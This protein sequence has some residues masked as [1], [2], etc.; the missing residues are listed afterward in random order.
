MDSVSMLD[1]RRHA[2]QI[3]RSV[4]KGRR[5]ELTYRGEV[6]ARLEPPEL[7]VAEDDAI[8]SLPELAVRAGESLTNRQIDEVVYGE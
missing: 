8:Y 2:Q 4:Q 3:I 7:A 6:V 1:F 5:L